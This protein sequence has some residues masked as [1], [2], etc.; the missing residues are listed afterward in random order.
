MHRL[1]ATVLAALLS[2]AV[3][4]GPAPAQPA[5]EAA[6]SLTYYQTV[7]GLDYH[8]LE[9]DTVTRY[10]NSTGGGVWIDY[11]NTPQ[12]LY[13]ESGIELPAGA[14]VTAVD[15]YARSCELAAF[16]QPRVY[17]GAYN[18]ASG[19]FA[20][21]IPETIV[22]L[23]GCAQTQTL[24]LA[25]DPPVTVDNSQYRYVVGYYQSNTYTDDN[26]DPDNVKSLLTGARVTYQIP[27]VFLPSIQR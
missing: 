26:Y 24:S 1:A 18:P 6:T 15:F 27:G 7:Y 12:F 23:A 9:S 17:F 16:N 20:Y 25:V 11:S 19:V 14:L 13:L 22:G 10:A 2:L 3:V 8:P 5:A 4:I 21:Y